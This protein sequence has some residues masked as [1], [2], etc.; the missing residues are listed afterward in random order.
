MRVNAVLADDNLPVTA[1][2]TTEEPGDLSK[3]FIEMQGP[4]VGGVLATM[5]CSAAKGISS[6]S[7]ESFAWRGALRLGEQS[8]AVGAGLAKGSSSTPRSAASRVTGTVRAAVGAAIDFSTIVRDPE[9]VISMGSC[10]GAARPGL[11]ARLHRGEL[12]FTSRRRITADSEIAVDFQVSGAGYRRSLQDVRGDAGHG[13]LQVRGLLFQ[14]GDDP[15]RPLSGSYDALD[16]AAL[17]AAGDGPAIA[18]GIR[19]VAA[20]R[21][22]YRYDA[23]D[24]TVVVYDPVQGNLM[25]FYRSHGAGLRHS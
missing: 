14:E 21:G 18:P 23:F 12:R 22:L 7:N 24:S 11:R 2:G 13:A 3:V 9:R 1:D 15:D 17:A 5:D 4:V 8:L 25:D 6:T 16:R 10:S 20:G 19:V